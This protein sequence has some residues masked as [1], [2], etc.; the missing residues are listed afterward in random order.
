MFADYHEGYRYQVQKW[1]KNPLDILIAELSKSKYSDKSIADFGC[2]EGKLQLQLEAN[3]VRTAKI[4][5]FDVGK[6]A[7]HVI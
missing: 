2:G 4:Y 5:S 7:D 1:P 3:A 6:C